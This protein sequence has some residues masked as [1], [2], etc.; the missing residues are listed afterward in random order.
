MHTVVI[1]DAEGQEHEASRDCDS[2]KKTDADPYVSL[3][4]YD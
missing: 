2:G 3:N 4:V 1:E